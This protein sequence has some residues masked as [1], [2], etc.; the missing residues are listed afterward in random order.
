MTQY[1]GQAMP[2]YEGIGQVTGNM[3]YVDDIVLPGMLYAKCLRSPVHKGILRH[4][5]LSAAEKTPGVVGILTAKDVPGRNIYG[6]SGDQPVFNP[7]NIRYKGER[8]AAV[9]AVDEDTCMEALE[10]IKLDIEEQ[11][12]VFDMFEALKPGAP[13]VRAGTSHNMHEYLPGVTTRVI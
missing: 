5:D 7:D 1:V 8:L 11:T 9:V 10:K 4:L 2:R 6:A 13:M 3:Q 12:P